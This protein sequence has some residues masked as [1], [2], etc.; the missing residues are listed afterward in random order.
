MSVPSLSKSPTSLQELCLS[1]ALNYPETRVRLLD[2]I[3]TTQPIRELANSKVKMQMEKEYEFRDKHSGLFLY[4]KFNDLRGFPQVVLTSNSYVIQI[5]PLVGSDKLCHEILKE[6]REKDGKSFFE[7]GE[8][9]KPSIAKLT[10]IER[11]EH[12]FG[13]KD[14]YSA[15]PIPIYT[16]YRPNMERE[17]IIK[18]IHYGFSILEKFDP[19]ITQIYLHFMSIEYPNLP[20]PSQLR[21]YKP[22]RI[23]ENTAGLAKEEISTI[24][25][26]QQP[27]QVRL[28]KPMKKKPVVPLKSEAVRAKQAALL[29]EKELSRPARPEKPAQFKPAVYMKAKAQ[30]EEEAKKAQD[31]KELSE[32]FNFILSRFLAMADSPRLIRYRIF[33]L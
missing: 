25:E 9:L 31:N 18:Q 13:E 8:E 10:P 23:H 15:I 27:V 4:K 11:I 1:A 3:E 12:I 29:A 19:S 26:H 14:P 28:Q 33:D 24:E 7:I 32:L 20:F 21:I 5:S 6:G 16:A 2:P 22:S 30:L 17:D